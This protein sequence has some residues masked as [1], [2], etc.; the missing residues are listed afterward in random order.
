[1]FISGAE[2]FAVHIKDL[3]PPNIS[4]ITL[5]QLSKV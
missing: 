1:M 4:Q 5:Y 2:R 3:F